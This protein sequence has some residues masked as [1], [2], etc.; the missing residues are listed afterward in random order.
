MAFH[1]TICFLKLCRQHCLG[2]FQVLDGLGYSSSDCRK[3]AR[4]VVR[5][6]LLWRERMQLD[7][8]VKPLAASCLCETFHSL[9]WTWLQS[10]ASNHLRQPWQLYSRIVPLFKP[11]RKSP[12]PSFASRQRESAK[13]RRGRGCIGFVADLR[14]ATRI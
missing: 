13:T 9:S 3:S 8:P 1:L 10:T 7:G 12:A 6:G 14:S 4:H 5:L 2:L 11:L